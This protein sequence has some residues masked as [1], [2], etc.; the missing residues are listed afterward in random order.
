[1]RDSELT[2]EVVYASIVDVRNGAR[3]G[4]KFSIVTVIHRL[5]HARRVWPFRRETVAPLPDLVSHVCFIR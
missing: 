1:M 3:V 4:I 2:R 5:H